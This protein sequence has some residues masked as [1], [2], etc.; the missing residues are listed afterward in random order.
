MDYLEDYFSTNLKNIISGNQ[1]FMSLKKIFVKICLKKQ[2]I[3]KLIILLILICI[4]RTNI[5]DDFFNDIKAVIIIL[6]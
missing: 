5:I 6:I 1:C 3:K 4:N 2:R